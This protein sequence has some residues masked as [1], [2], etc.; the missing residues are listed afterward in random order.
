[1]EPVDTRKLR[2]CCGR[3]RNWKQL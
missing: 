2:W 3:A 1:M